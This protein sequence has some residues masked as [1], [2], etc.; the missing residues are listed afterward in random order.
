[1]LEA[2]LPQPYCSDGRHGDGLRE[3]IATAGVLPVPAMRRMASDFAG[4]A[5]MTDRPEWVL[6][7][8]V[9]AVI[10][11]GLGFLAGYLVWG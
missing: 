11:L 7:F 5:P 3:G 8:G 6:V 1:M 2:N 4:A 9:L 10:Y